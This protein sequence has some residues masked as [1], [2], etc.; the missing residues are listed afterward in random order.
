MN[1]TKEQL[2]GLLCEIV[3]HHEKSNHV[4]SIEQIQENSKWQGSNE[5]CI[6]C[7]FGIYWTKLDFHLVEAEYGWYC[8]I[9]LLNIKKKPIQIIVRPLKC[10]KYI[11]L[12]F[13]LA[14]D[15]SIDLSIDNQNDCSCHS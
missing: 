5:N 7:D 12:N 9:C 13:K 1:M 11:T 3:N 10:A 8:P 2:Q 15:K 6:C 4:C 14:D